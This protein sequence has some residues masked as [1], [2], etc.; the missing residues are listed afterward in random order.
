LRLK[1]STKRIGHPA[2][3]AVLTYPK[4]GAYSNIARAQVNLPASEFLDQG[5]LNK[6]CTKPVLLEG[7]CSAKS[8]YGKAKVWTPLLDK[9][10][11]G[12]VYLV[13]GYGFKLPALVAELDGQI[14]VVLKGKV[15]SGPN[16]G[17]RNTF[18]AVPDAPV[19]RFVLEMKGG[20][21]Y[22]L[23]EN[24][25]NLCKRPQRAIVRFA[26][27]N[28]LVAQS[29]PLVSNQCRTRNG[30]RPKKPKKAQRGH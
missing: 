23:L 8:I 7:K 5:N 9:P 24:S 19:S 21:K 11:E 3:K 30:D 10:L 13:G 22:G 6:T 28:G 4:E 15:D 25:E 17:I 1:G 12:P 18:E 2:L 29:K 26:A 20:K 14:R 27:Q 16:K